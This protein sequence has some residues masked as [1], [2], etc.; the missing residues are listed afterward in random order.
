MKK[1]IFLSILVAAL[2]IGAIVYADI[3]NRQLAEG[4]PYGK[5]NLNPATIEQLSD[6]LYDNLIMPDELKAKLDNQEDMFVYFYSPLCVHCKA[7]TPVLVPIVKSLDIDMKKHNLLEFN[8]SYQDYQI[9]FTPTLVHYKGGKEVARLV[10]GR[11]AS[12]WKAWLEEQK[13]S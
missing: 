6:P 12:E 5:A 11:E 8:A 2:L 1:V 10:G 9:E 13:K 7:T 4:N 3:S